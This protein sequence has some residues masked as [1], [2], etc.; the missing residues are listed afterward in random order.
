M[1]EPGEYVPSTALLNKGWSLFDCNFLYS[2]SVRLFAN[3]LG[4][5]VGELTR[6]NISPLFG[7]TATTAPFLPSSSSV[8]SF[9]N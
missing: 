6:V 1:V 7:S 8:A 4:L 3:R 9:Y 2:F 5:Y